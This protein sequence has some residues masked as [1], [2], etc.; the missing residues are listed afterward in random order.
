MS[1]QDTAPCGTVHLFI[2]FPSTCSFWFIYL[3]FCLLQLHHRLYLAW[4]STTCSSYAILLGP[5]QLAVHILSV[6]KFTAN[7][8]CI[9]LSIILLNADAVQICCKFLDT[10]YN[11]SSTAWPYR[12]SHGNCYVFVTSD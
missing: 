2:S 5:T 10:Q 9:S 8:Y 11:Q 4:S 6:P 12:L 7:L 1:A 3:T